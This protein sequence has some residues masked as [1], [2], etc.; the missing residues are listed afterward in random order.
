MQHAPRLDDLPSWSEDDRLGDLDAL[1]SPAS[2]WALNLSDLAAPALHTGGSV[3]ALG[4]EPNA[5][6][7]RQIKPVGQ[8]KLVAGREAQKRFRQRNKVETCSSSCRCQLKKMMHVFD[9][10]S[11]RRPWKQIIL[12]PRLS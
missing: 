6:Q 3:Q 8:R 11:K 5:G 1:V 12:L 2:D 4:A 10:R 7:Q 9:S